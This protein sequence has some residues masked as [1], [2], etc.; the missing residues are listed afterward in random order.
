M[1]EWAKLLVPILLT[2]SILGLMG[3][4]HR[5][6]SLEKD[7]VRRELLEYRLDRIEKECNRAIQ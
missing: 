3:L 6:E 7:T 2:V 5:I 1:N 4:Y